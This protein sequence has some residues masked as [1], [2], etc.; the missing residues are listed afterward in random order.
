MNQSDHRRQHDAHPALAGLTHPDKDV[1]QQTAVALGSRA[2]PLLTPAVASLLWGESDFFVR[3]TLT[4]VLTRTP[5]TAVDAATQALTDPDPAVR[6]QA[7]HVLSKIKHPDSAAAVKAC[8]DDQDTAVAERAQWALARIGDPSVL[9][10]LITRLG[11][12]DLAGRDSLTSTLAQFGASAVPPLVTALTDSNPSV[13]M[14]Q[15]TVGLPCRRTV[16]LLAGGQFISLS[17][18]S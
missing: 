9:P 16:D 7:L 13:R 11:Q 8:L 18:V 5:T 6:T 10:V 15:G 3:E 14:C 17:V 12:T 4:W 2:D 1:R